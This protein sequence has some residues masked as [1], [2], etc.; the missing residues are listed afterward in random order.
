MPRELIKAEAQVGWDDEE[1]GPWPTLKACATLGSLTLVTHHV[2]V[3]SSSP[4]D[5]WSSQSLDKE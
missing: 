4:V 3:F 5:K 2:K 1:V